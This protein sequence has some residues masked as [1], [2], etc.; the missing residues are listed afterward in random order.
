MLKVTEIAAAIAAGTMTPRTAIEASIAAIAEKEPAIGAFEALADPSVLV[1]RAAQATGPLAGIA[2]G[3]KDIFDT[4]DLPTRY[5]SPIYDGHRP[6][7]DAPI[8]SLAR[9]RGASI[10]GKTVTTEFAF[11][12]PGRTVNPHNFAHTPGGSS[13]GSAAAVAAGMVPAAFGTQT[14]GS[15]IRPAAYCG[16]AGYK[17]SFRLVPAIGM[18][19]LAWTL[20][21]IGF[22]AAGAADVALFAELLTGRPLSAEPVVP[23][24]TTIG[25]YRSGIWSE[26]SPAMQA[27]VETLAE[28]AS[29]AGARVIDMDEPEALSAAR[30]AHLIIQ[31]FEASHALGD[32]FARH[33]EKLS[34]VLR[35][36]LVHGNAI[37]PREYDDAR[38]IARSA[39]HTANELFQ[40]VDALLT[41]SAPGTAPRGLEKTGAPIFNKLWTLAGTP[42]VNVP[43]MTDGGLPLGVQVV[44]RFGRDRQVLSLAAWL[45]GLI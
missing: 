4:Y 22:F 2:I 36:T 30:D 38:R 25:I 20:D 11:F 19:N 15:T 40:S 7:S 29:K 31:N 41:P 3:I 35:D 33:A 23:A 27:A 5:G 28:R 8:V 45:E 6:A 12:H 17:P 14:A 24:E 16:I 37:T 18:K 10:A 32:E 13:S 1:D 34:P 43:G 44:S 42:C 39:R 26:A 21:T 9:R